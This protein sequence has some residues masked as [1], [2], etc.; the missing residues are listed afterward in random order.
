[1]SYTALIVSLASK[2]H[3]P[4]S[5]SILTLTKSNL[6]ESTAAAESATHA[7]GKTTE[8]CRWLQPH[9]WLYLVPT[10][11]QV[12][13]IRSLVSHGREGTLGSAKEFI[14]DRVCARCMVAEC[15]MPRYIKALR[16]ARGVEDSDE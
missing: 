14:C 1:M 16:T 12:N 15:R 5:M 10:D 9:D 7:P 11:E 3:G 4:R 8:R 2:S 6:A 13:E